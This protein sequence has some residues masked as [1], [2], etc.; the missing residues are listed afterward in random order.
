MP[1]P[2]LPPSPLVAELAQRLSTRIADFKPRPTVLYTPPALPQGLYD[3]LLLPGTL[4]LVPNPAATLQQ[5]QPHLKPE[6]AL[7]GWVLGEGSFP[8]LHTACAQSALPPPP[9]LPAV[10]DVGSLLQTLGFALPVVDKEPL[11]LTTPTFA[12]LLHHLKTHHALQRPMGGG[13]VTPRQLKQLEEA[14]PRNAQGLPT[15]TLNILFFHA[16]QP[17]PNLPHAAK[18]G[19]AKIP[20]ITILGPDAPP[21]CHPPKTEKQ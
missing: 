11:T 18:R 7:L 10:Q 13:L 21:P 1:L 17:G 19:S 8:E 5:L 2:T 3:A 4:S 20:A 15:L 6:G 9:A 14:Y 16:L 12:R